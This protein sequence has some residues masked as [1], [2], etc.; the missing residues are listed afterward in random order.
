MGPSQ[1][2]GGSAELGDYVNYDSDYNYDLDLIVPHISPPFRVPFGATSLSDLHSMSGVSSGYRCH[3]V[4]N[5]DEVDSG[6]SIWEK[7]SSDTNVSRHSNCNISNQETGEY[8]KCN[9]N[10][11]CMNS[12]EIRVTA[13]AEPLN[14]DYSTMAPE[15]FP[16]YVCPSELASPRQ[17]CID[18]GGSNCNNK[19]DQCLQF[20][21][22]LGAEFLEM[23]SG[24]IMVGCQETG[25]V[26]LVTALK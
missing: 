25:T 8:C 21:K 5:E 16:F 2:S 15:L 9:D 10:L 13:N 22:C 6:Q 7:Y 18:D 3:Y 19:V 24:D 12:A 23:E 20:L 14:V 26:P 1:K 4:Y 17:K 11:K